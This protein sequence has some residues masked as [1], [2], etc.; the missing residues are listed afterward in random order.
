MRLHSAFLIYHNR[1]PRI[2]NREEH[3]V[4]LY[5]LEPLEFLLFMFSLWLNIERT[6]TLSIP[7]VCESWVTELFW[8]VHH[9]LICTLCSPWVFFFHQ[10][11]FW[12]IFKG[13]QNWPSIIPI[14]LERRK[15]YN[16]LELLGRFLLQMLYKVRNNFILMFTCGVIHHQKNA[17]LTLIKLELGL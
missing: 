1:I 10:T 5:C 16:F 4:I 8:N 6:L 17:M 9:F 7:P 11:L 12:N 3:C 13:N 2:A 15:H 14:W